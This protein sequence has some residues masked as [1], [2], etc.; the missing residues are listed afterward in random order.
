MIS[1]NIAYIEIFIFKSCKCVSFYHGL[2]LEFKSK[3]KL[4]DQQFNFRTIFIVWMF[5]N[6]SCS[7]DLALQNKFKLLHDEIFNIHRFL[8]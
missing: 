7:D 8:E 1:V 2:F 4:G 6:F 3:L 5:N